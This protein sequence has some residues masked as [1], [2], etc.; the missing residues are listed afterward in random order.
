M[1]SYPKVT[2]ILAVFNGEKTIHGCLETLLNQSVLP[3]I[4]V[5]D[6]GSTDKTLRILNKFNQITI[7]KQKHQGPA[8]A[9]NLGAKKA[10]GMILIFADADMT[11]DR[12]YIKKLITPI[13]KKQAIG[14]YTVAERV[15]NWE[16]IWARCWNI[17]EGWQARK[18]FPPNPPKWGTDYR[19]ILKSE[20]DRVGGFD[21]IGY[22]DTWTLFQKLRKKP[23]RTKA[24]CYHKNPSSLQTVYKQA[25]WAAKRPYKLGVLGTLYA[26][27]RSSLPVSIFVGLVKSITNN[28]P[29]FFIFKLVYDWGRFLGILQMVLTGKTFK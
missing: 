29:A 2:I 14:T 17:Q 25:K 16:N 4:I 6:D 7:I 3:Q 15:S 28:N 27:T 24:I 8:I 12:H 21:N 20:F 9:R 22:T 10:R 23:L 13:I 5:V 11:F 19:A 1:P 26:L 18:R